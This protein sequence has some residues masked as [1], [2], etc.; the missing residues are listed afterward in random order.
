MRVS[1]IWIASI[2]LSAVASWE[3]TAAQSPAD[4]TADSPIGLMRR[5]EHAYEERD[6]D[7]YRELFTADFLF[8]PSDPEVAARCPNGWHRED[9]IASADHLFHGFT[10]RMGV[11]RPAA[12]RIVLDLSP[13]E[14][15]ADPEHPDSTAYYRRYD[16]P[17][18]TLQIWTPAQNFFISDQEHVYYVVR[19]D[20]AVLDESQERSADVWYI[21]KWV[22]N[23]RWAGRAL[24][25]GDPDKVSNP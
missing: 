19:G 13:Y 10:D 1:R 6:L 16:V 8:L 7:R 17:S 2:A 23:P 3:Q 15:Q 5:F 20:A 18:V 12:T 24:A 11:Y 9:E 14:E 25:S 21:R 22:E 4:Y